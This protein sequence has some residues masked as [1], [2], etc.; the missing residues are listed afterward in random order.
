M[1][2]QVMPE[3]HF[4]FRNCLDRLHVRVDARHHG[5]SVALNLLVL[6]HGTSRQ[7]SEPN[8]NSQR[9]QRSNSAPAFHVPPPLSENAE[10][11]QQVSCRLAY[12]APSRIFWRFELTRRQPSLPCRQERVANRAVPRGRSH[13]ILSAPATQTD[14]HD[15]RAADEIMWHLKK[16]ETSSSRRAFRGV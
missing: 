7:H 13:A 4:S 16:L 8:Q 3:W 6:C 10:R 9:L 1:I 14:P 11:A 5:G 12:T 2:R 15:P